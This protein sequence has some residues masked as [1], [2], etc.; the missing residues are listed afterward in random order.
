MSFDVNYCVMSTSVGIA[1]VNLPK[2]TLIAISQR[3]P[4]LNNKALSA[5]RR[6][7]PLALSRGLLSMNEPEK[8]MSIQQ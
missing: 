5:S 3:L 7:L 1:T 8:R 2:H 6:A 4:M